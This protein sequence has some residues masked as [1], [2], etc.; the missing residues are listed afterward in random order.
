MTEQLIEDALTAF[1]DRE[2][3][4]PGRD[5]LRIALD[6]FEASLARCGCVKCT[7][8]RRERINL[9]DHDRTSLARVLHEIVYS[10]GATYDRA[11]PGIQEHLLACAEKVA[12]ALPWLV[13]H[14]PTD[15][16]QGP[17]ANCHLCVGAG[18]YEDYDGE[19]VECSCQ[20]QPQGEP[21]DAQVDAAAKT[22]AN[23]M[24]DGPW[25]DLLDTFQDDYRHDARAALRAA[26]GVR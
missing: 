14:T 4:A 18:G 20:R 12:A 24:G 10:P 7:T 15:D 9:S 6:A 21:S 5:A 23:R 26:G 17:A 13:P 2:V 25:E 16:E 19:W 1:A 8:E 11:V 22:L 3:P